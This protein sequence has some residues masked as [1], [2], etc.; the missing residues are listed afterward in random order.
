MPKSNS[1]YSVSL[2]E[3]SLVKLSPLIRIKSFFF[4][5]AYVNIATNIC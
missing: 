3:S 4:P 5:Q 2:L 1:Y